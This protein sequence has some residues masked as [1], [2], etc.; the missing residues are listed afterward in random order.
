MRKVLIVDITLREAENENMPYKLRKQPR[1]QLYWVVN[2][3]TKKKYS[4]E[5]IPKD[6]AQH[7]LNLLRAV[8]H[9]WKPSKSPKKN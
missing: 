4:H 6:R 7:Q 8:E 2:I 3:D 1:T 9:G 5:P